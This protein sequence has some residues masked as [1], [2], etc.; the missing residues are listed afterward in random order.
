MPARARAAPPF[1]VEDLMS[2]TEFAQYALFFVVLTVSVK[3]TGMYL[4]AVFGEKPT[5]LDRWFGPL[6]RCVYRLAWVDPAAPMNWR[7]YA[8]AFAIF[9]V[10]G[11]ALLYGILEMQAFLPDLSHIQ[12]PFVTPLSAD[13]A[14]N[15][16][17]SFATTT[18]WQAYAGETTLTYFSQMAGLVT[19][20]FLAG[21]AGLAVGIAFMRGFARQRTDDL[22]N[23]WRDLVLGTVR[24]LLPIACVASLILVWQGVP[25]NWSPY[26]AAT[27]LQGDSQ[28]IPQGPVAALESIKNLG[29][30]GGGFFNANAAHPYENPTPLSNL[31]EML[32]IAVLPAGLTCT[33][34]RMIGR[35]RHGW[36]L[37]GIMSALFAAGLASANWAEHQ[38]P[39]YVAALPVAAVADGASLEGKETRFGVAASVLG[40]VT[41]SNGATGSTNSMHDSFSALGGMVPLLNMLLGEVVYGGLGTGIYSIVLVILLAAFVGGLMVGRTP[42]YL[43]KRIGPDEAKLIAIYYLMSGAFVLVLT[44]IA[45]VTPWGLAG[46]TTNQ[47]PHGFT[48]ILFTYASCFSNNGQTFAGLSVNSPAYNATTAIAML[49]GRFGLAIPALALAGRFA[50]QSRRI[51]SAA[52]ISPDSWHFVL[53]V[54]G[55]LLLTAGLT[56]FPA[57]ILGP[58]AEHLGF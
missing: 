53:L 1:S 44:A 11:I 14:A 50:A 51:E 35:P 29:T 33:F 48:S 52:S 46:L 58:I 21:A 43:Q 19:Q 26:A 3:P 32:L 49:G 7:Q 31:V 30:N 4:E 16:A 45:V 47:G 41:T 23:F 15:I 9:T 2:G 10:A 5:A 57:L 20:N 36:V 25:M 34:G 27:T 6:E 38:V 17:V 55:V 13:L 18:T 42:V 54:V 12:A 24:I 40:A 56:F 28:I 8:S 22:G 39:A 37:Y